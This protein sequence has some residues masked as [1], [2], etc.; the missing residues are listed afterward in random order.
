MNFI[1]VGWNNFVDRERERTG[2]SQE[3]RSGV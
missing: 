2:N 3:V 1:V